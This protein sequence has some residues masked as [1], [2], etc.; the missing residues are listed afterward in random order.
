MLKAREHV[1]D[2]IFSPGR[3]PQVEVSGQLV[4]LKFKGPRMPGPRRHRSDRQSPPRQ[5]INTQP[6][7]RGRRL[8]RLSY[9]LENI[10][11][12]RVNIFRQRG[13]LRHRHARDSDRIPIFDDLKLPPQLQ[14][15]CG[16]CAMA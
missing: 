15:I 3:A 7:V 4:E 1:S 11:R 10:G 6:K 14:E 8:R 16:A 5:K 9:G 13:S 12:F 2:L